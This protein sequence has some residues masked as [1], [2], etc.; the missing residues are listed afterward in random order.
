MDS[1]A[2]W[3]LTVAL[4]H[5]RRSK[6]RSARRRT[7]EQGAAT[8]AWIA[9]SDPRHEVWA[10][11]AALPRREREAVALRYL[12]DLTEPQIAEVMGVAV[13]TVGA[14]LTSARRRLATAL[15]TTDEEIDA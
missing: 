8:T 3:I 10:A 14:T 4:N 6:R 5:L 12:A 9:P 11:V 2:G 1:P 15:E 7:A 13:G